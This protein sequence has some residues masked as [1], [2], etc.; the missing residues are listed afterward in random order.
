MTDSDATLYNVACNVTV[1]SVTGTLFTIGEAAWSTC[2]NS[3]DEEKKK[4]RFHLSL[5]K[6][7]DDHILGF[8][9]LGFRDFEIPG[10]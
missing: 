8:P 3:H 9:D 5:H 6:P 7:S 10:F 1:P 2:G 4:E